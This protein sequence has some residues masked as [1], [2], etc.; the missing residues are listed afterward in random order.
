VI[1]GQEPPMERA[2]RAA[3]GGGR[4]VVV[5]GYGAVGQI[6]ATLLGE[7]FPGQVV[8]AGRDL[9]RA[10]EL[11]GRVGHGL[12]PHR[13]DVDRPDDVDST[14][15]D[16]RL[17]VMCVE[18]ANETLARECLRRGIGYVDICATAPVLAAIGRLHE[19]AVSTAATAVLSV[20]LA[21]GLTNVLARRCVDRLPS[22][23]SVDITV[24]LGA[25]GDH[26]PDS[27]RWTV[28][29]LGE[30][31]V[32]NGASS[33]RRART[34]LPGF[35]RRR[36]YAFP[37]SDQHTLST[38]LG[39][40]VTT[41]LCFDSALLTGLLFSVRAT[42]FFSLVR[43]VGGD[44]LLSAALSGLRIGTDRFLVHAVA[45]GGDGE[46]VW[47]AAGG[48]QE[49]RATAIV[50]AHVARRLYH[51]GLPSGVHHLDQL[52]DAKA[53]LDELPREHFTVYSEAAGSG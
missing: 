20:G 31:A 11:T 2:S 47:Y 50:T 1:A 32:R 24:L 33:A 34:W 18:R 40:P 49:S 6:V 27:V 29:Q 53:F 7:W 4:I 36:A 10:R 30:R 13:L 42:G 52:V 15:R 48:H 21:P 45:T 39:V 3:S 44:R 14:L 17:V 43:R 37:F 51:G 19:T 26:G 8:V 25:G 41:R 23:R 28:R 12:I 35:G 9:S 46:R 38:T 22:A 5:G 16:A